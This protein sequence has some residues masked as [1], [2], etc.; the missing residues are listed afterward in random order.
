MGDSHDLVIRAATVFDGT[1]A[2]GVVAD[3][4]VD[5]ER[6]VDVGREV[7]A[8]RRE[9]VASGLAL[10]PGFIDVHTHDD[11]ALLVQPDLS[12]KTM[13]GVTT[14][15]TGN[16]GFGPAPVA[17]VA[18]G[19]STFDR[20]RDFLASVE[21]AGPAVNVAALA[22]HG[23]IRAAVMGTTTPRVAERD[24]RARMAEL[25][26][27]ALEDGAVG[28]SSGLA[29]EPGRYANAEE[30]TAL[31]ALVAAAGG[32]YTTHMR[33]E[34]D[35]LLASIDEAIAVGTAS[36]VKVQIS[37][38]KANGSGNRGRAAAALDRI[39]RA[40]RR[41]VD[42]MADQYPY[43]RGSTLLEQVVSAGALDGASAFGKL[44]GDQ[45]LIAA[46][47][48][49]SE[50]EGRTL[51]ELAAEHGLGDKAMA[52]TIVAALGR[53]CIVVLDTMSE[54]DVRL[55]MRHPSVIVG[56]DGIAA[57]GKP[58]PRLAH[59]FPR[60]LGTYTRELGVL[61][62]ADAVHRMTGASARRFGLADRGE[63][64]PGAFA[65]LVLFDPATIVDTGTYADPLTPPIG[66]EEVWVN[67]AT[68][69]RAGTVTESRPGRV[70]RRASPP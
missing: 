7:G 24:E 4:A 23:S 57:G 67:G 14:V 33:D 46:A 8:G 47:P 9:I 32:I 43:T 27:A 12:F 68:V 39:E 64:R 59:T 25:L 44:R 30:I 54:D 28:M 31:A 11:W 49:R 21:N 56:S 50:W 66:I 2:P 37:H 61:N 5:G 48:R 17:D 1:G 36:G 34:S 65:D 19:P 29:Y 15:V 3:V 53:S 51:A 26:E 22:G 63:I 16:C 10:T 40:Q 20:M 35:G 38:L 45:V 52:E 60:V 70:L 13:Q 42:V 18:F 62:L 58:H 69:V 6:I 55:I 41:G